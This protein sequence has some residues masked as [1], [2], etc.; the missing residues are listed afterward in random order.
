LKSVL[1]LQGL[2][3][4]KL[5]MIIM[6]VVVVMMMMMMMIFTAEK[7]TTGH[8]MDQSYDHLHNSP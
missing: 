6:V 2:H 8:H 4:N 3:Q 5:A 7:K 1:Q